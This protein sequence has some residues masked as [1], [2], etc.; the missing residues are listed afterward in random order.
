MESAY[1]FIHWQVAIAITLRQTSLESHSSLS[2]PSYDTPVKIYNLLVA[3]MFKNIRRLGDMTSTTTSQ[4][5]LNHLCSPYIAA[6]L[7][8]AF[9]SQ[10][11]PTSKALINGASLSRND[12]GQTN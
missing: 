5:K 8:I 11:H 9:A 7:S 6:R 10:K 4:P 12:T 1:T 3:M 2:L